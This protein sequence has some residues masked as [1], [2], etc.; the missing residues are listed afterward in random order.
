M[1]VHAVQ[2][3]DPVAETTATRVA[4]IGL[5]SMGLRDGPVDAS[6]QGSR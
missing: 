2:K 5:G 4:V 6:A 3:E 1:S